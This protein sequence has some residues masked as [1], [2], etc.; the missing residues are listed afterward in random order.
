MLMTRQCPGKKVRLLA[1]LLVAWLAACTTTEVSKT[2]P[3]VKAETVLLLPVDAL[4]DEL[5]GQAEPVNRLL[6]DE[7][8]SRKFQVISSDKA[9]YRQAVD[10]ALE[11][12]G[13]MYDPKVGKF[14]PAD[15]NKYWKALIDIYAVNEDFDVMI[16]PELAIRQA[17]TDGDYAEWDDARRR[18]E[19]AEK[20][21]EP[22]RHPPTLS[23]LSVKLTAFTAGGV[24]IVQSHGG[25]SLPYLV[26]HNQSPPTL[27]L[28]KTLFT[29]KELNQG[30]DTA[31][32][33]I[34]HQVI[35]HER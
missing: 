4:Y 25:V 19:L 22:Y 12:S 7:L 30:V 33:N 18:I 21:D 11:I 26:N 31:L 1:P 24:F 5:A 6:A 23:G 28:K 15:R 35:Y 10:Q 9:V 27:K 17:Q 29:D 34:F 20:A 32:E 3:K 13:A 16:M 8:S 14:L 2:A